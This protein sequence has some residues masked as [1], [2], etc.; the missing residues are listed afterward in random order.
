MASFSGLN[1][2][3]VMKVVVSV[4]ELHPRRFIKSLWTSRIHFSAVGSNLDDTV[5]FF[6]MY[7]PYF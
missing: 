1:P 7:L 6:L 3:L 2:P 4:G 5:W